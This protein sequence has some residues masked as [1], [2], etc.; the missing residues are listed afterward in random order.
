[1]KRC[2]PASFTPSLLWQ[3][4]EK[5]RPVSSWLPERPARFIPSVPLPPPLPE[6]ERGRKLVVAPLSVSGRRSVA[7]RGQADAVDQAAEVDLI[8]ITQDARVMAMRS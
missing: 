7:A 6:A 5:T 3:T 2:C 4:A 8:A 1:M